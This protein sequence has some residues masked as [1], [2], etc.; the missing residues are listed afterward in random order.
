MPRAHATLKSRTMRSSS[1]AALILDGWSNCMYFCVLCFATKREFNEWS[2]NRD[3]KSHSDLYSL[4]DY[5]SLQAWAEIY[6]CFDY[7]FHRNFSWNLQFPSMITSKRKLVNWLFFFRQLRLPPF[8]S[9][10]RE[11]DSCL[12]PLISFSIKRGHKHTH[13][14]V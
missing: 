13:E 9:R 1:N 5:D 10:S 2:C 14:N 7:S 3:D 4:C 6:F 8:S 11:L 12:L